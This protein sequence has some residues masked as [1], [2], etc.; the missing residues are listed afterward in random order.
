MV[1]KKTI[2]LICAQNDSE[3][4]CKMILVF[5]KDHLKTQSI[6]TIRTIHNKQI[7]W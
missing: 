3:V 6:F 1:E 5:L 4:N 2:R 7:F